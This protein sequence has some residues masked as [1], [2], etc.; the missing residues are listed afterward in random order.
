MN[1]RSFD[2]RRV[3]QGVAGAL[4]VVGALGAAMQPSSLRAA[5]DAGYGKP[6]LLVDSVWLAKHRQ[7]AN[8]RVLD[9]RDAKAYATAHIPGAVHL[10]ESALRNPADKT[11]YLPTPEAFGALMSGVGVANDTHVVLYDDQSSRPSAR[12]WYVLN[13][14]GHPKV[15]ILNGGWKQYAL[16]NSAAETETPKVADTKFTPRVVPDLSCPAPQLLA[17]KPGVVVLDARSPEEYAGTQTSGGAA[18][19]GRVPGSVNVDWR[20]NV[21][22]PNGAFKS[23]EEL[24]KMYV[25]KGVTPDKEIVTYCASGGRLLRSN[26]A[27]L[28]VAGSLVAR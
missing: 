25:A 14:Y 6:E 18:K 7:D 2:R 10:N 11:T 16:E 1:E 19:A 8:V 3:L 4:V 15:S 13:A 22:G 26:Q 24:R 23:A 20:E 27:L 5:P 12:L 21:A 17:R 9:L 28:D